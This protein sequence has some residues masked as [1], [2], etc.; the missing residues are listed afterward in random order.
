MERD[1]QV[2]E[3]T[4]RYRTGVL[5]N[6]N[7]LEQYNGYLRNQGEPRTLQQLISNRLAKKP[8]L[9]VLDIGC[10]DAGA[11]SELKKEFGDQLSVIGIDLVTPPQKKVDAFLPGDALSVPFPSECD[12]VFSFRALHEAGRIKDVI[13]KVLDCLAKDGV[14]L[15]SIRV[16]E[17]VAGKPV[18]LGQMTIT[19]LDFLTDLSLNK[20][21]CRI[22][23]TVFFDSKEKAVVTGFFLKIEKVA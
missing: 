4:E 19:D 18:F 15:L 12:V 7:S 21:G 20:K 23:K 13:E 1:K 6:H 17:P 14:A 8:H 3:L 9:R 22:T 5:D 16:A 11:L 2:K 10:G